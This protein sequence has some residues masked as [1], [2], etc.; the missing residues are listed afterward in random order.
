[1]RFFVLGIIVLTVTSKSL[2][3]ELSKNLNA[4]EIKRAAAVLGFSAHHRPFTAHSISEG[5]LG[6]DLGIESAF[7]LRRDLLHQGDASAVI[8]RT[9]PVPRIWISWEFPY[10]LSFSASVAPGFLF[11][12]VT[13]YGV[14]L[15]WFFYEYS[16]LNTSISF[17]TNF[18]SVSAFDDINAKV[19]TF[20]VQASRDLAI[21]QPYC[22]IGFALQA[23]RVNTANA[24]PGV[25]A[26]RYYQ[27]RPHSFIGARID[28]L[29]KLSVQF[30]FYGTQ[31]SM[32]LLLENAF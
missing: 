9:I 26:G 15:Q 18:S 30:D 6:L 3:T 1:M 20:D 28:L 29:T 21:W 13:S 23:A 25:S 8:P 12:G 5:D 24:A 32:G 7:I 11:D 31:T 22:G 2:A 19:F 14:G 4:T 16:E 17:V 27:V 10:D